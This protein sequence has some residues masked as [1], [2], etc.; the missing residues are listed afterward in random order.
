MQRYTIKG[1]CQPAISY[2][3]SGLCWC[4]FLTF[5]TLEKV[6]NPL[7]I[8]PEISPVQFQILKRA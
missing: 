1:D 3:C 6:I 8:K 7:I 5:Q 4:E 2:A